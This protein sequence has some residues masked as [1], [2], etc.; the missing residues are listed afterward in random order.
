MTSFESIITEQANGKVNITSKD[1]S[2]DMVNSPAS[3]SESIKNNNGSSSHIKKISIQAVDITKTR[4]YKEIYADN[5]R[6]Y[7]FL[8]AKVIFVTFF[9][10]DNWLKL[11]LKALI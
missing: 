7:G 9:W 8:L 6:Q 10:K 11:A 4:Q 1:I 2:Q 5:L 3:G